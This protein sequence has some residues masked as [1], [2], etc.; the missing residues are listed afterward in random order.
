MTED[1]F[2]SMFSTEPSPTER[3]PA[4]GE[5]RSVPERPDT[6]PRVVAVGLPPVFGQQIAR[7]FASGAQAQDDEVVSWAPTVTSAED[8]LVASPVPPEAIVL[9]PASS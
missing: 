5:P 7:V 1:A 8:L 9:S 6:P 2:G 4:F 3:A